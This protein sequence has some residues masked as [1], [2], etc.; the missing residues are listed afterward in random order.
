M[1][2]HSDPVSSLSSKAKLQT[3]AKFLMA[4][5]KLDSYLDEHPKSAR[6]IQHELRDI[7]L[8]SGG[9]EAPMDSGHTF[10]LPRRPVKD[11]GR[12]G[13]EIVREF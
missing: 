6:R 8:L 13:D 12:D 2:N 7:S 10:K 1:G 3:P 4:T 5:K 11:L 9:H